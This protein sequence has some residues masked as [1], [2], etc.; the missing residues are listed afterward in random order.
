MKA[1]IKKNE[2]KHR[3]STDDGS[4]TAVQFQVLFGAA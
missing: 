1:H 2:S 4:V 3:L